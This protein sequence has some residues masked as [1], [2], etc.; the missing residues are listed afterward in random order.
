MTTLLKA[1]LSGSTD[2][3][4]MSKIYLDQLLK[5]PI[6]A[7]LDETEQLFAP[8]FDEEGMRDLREEFNY[9]EQD[10]EGLQYDI[11]EYQEI[12]FL[13][14]KKEPKLSDTSKQHPVF[15]DT[16][17]KLKSAYQELTRLEPQ[18][19]G[20]KKTYNEWL[21]LVLERDDGKDVT[22]EQVA[23]II[24]SDESGL[25]KEE[26]IKILEIGIDLLRM[27]KKRLKIQ[28]ESI[29][30]LPDP[31]EVKG[32][33]KEMD[34]EQ[35]K[36]M[37]DVPKRNEHGVKVSGLS[38][39]ERRQEIGQIQA[40]FNIKI[41]QLFEKDSQLKERTKVREE[42]GNISSRINAGLKE[43]KSREKGT[44]LSSP[45]GYEQI[46]HPRSKK[47]R[48]GRTKDKV[49]EHLK[50]P[51]KKTPISTKGFGTKSFIQTLA[52]TSKSIRGDNTKDNFINDLYTFLNHEDMNVMSEPKEYRA[53]KW[54]DEHGLGKIAS[55]GTITLAPPKHRLLNLRQLRHIIKNAPPVVKEENAPI[56]KRILNAIE[57]E[58][59]LE[60]EREKKW[61]QKLTVGGEKRGKLAISGL[62]KLLEKMKSSLR[63]YDFEGPLPKAFKEQLVL[64][65]KSNLK[66][67]DLVKLSKGKLPEDK[68]QGM[69][70]EDM[71]EPITELLNY[72]FKGKINLIDVITEN[73]SKRESVEE[74][75]EG[76]NYIQEYMDKLYAELNPFLSGEEE[77]EEE[78]SIDHAKR[79]KVF[80]TSLVTIVKRLDDENITEGSQAYSVIIRDIKEKFSHLDDIMGDIE[81]SLE[82]QD[83]KQLDNIRDKFRE[84]LDL[85][86]ERKPKL[87]H[88]I[89]GE[90]E[91][92]LKRLYEYVAEIQE[93]AKSGGTVTR[94]PNP[95]KDSEIKS[96]IKAEIEK[97]DKNLDDK[98]REERIEHIRESYP[99]EEYNQELDAEDWVK[100]YLRIE[101]KLV[102]SDEGIPSFQEVE[103]NYKNINDKLQAYVNGHL[104]SPKRQDYKGKNSSSRYKND[105]QR[106]QALIRRIAKGQQIDINDLK[107]RWKPNFTK[108]VK[109]EIELDIKEL[110]NIEIDEEY[111]ESD[112]GHRETEEL[113]EGREGESY[114]ELTEE[115]REN[116]GDM[117]S[118]EYEEQSAEEDEERRAQEIDQD[119]L[120]QQQEQEE[121]EEEGEG[122]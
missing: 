42:I 63:R 110:D 80:L 99:L 71:L 114:E 103:G 66:T 68:F 46:E 25:S 2:P 32:L 59:T 31:K 6:R 113:L 50:K 37:A 106:R 43:I 92:I 100:H 104:P 47:E 26:E 1:Y 83:R 24:G 39:S 9:L 60:E 48:E 62:V 112:V 54:A 93:N 38:H 118:E 4:F 45:V 97:L 74:S 109:R 17:K 10:I 87:P 84:Y 61:E 67:W 56:H 86:E 14:E 76:A 3:F 88:K 15:I 122:V 101:E 55:S 105:L 34:K 85:E 40:R 29:L 77:P 30:N 70:S 22:R 120:E 64:L 69:L 18:L 5:M 115:E 111:D 53:K 107:W 121:L 44:S 36:V 12:I 82:E 11:K 108:K 33:I 57:K 72:S 90:V 20:L 117:T 89:K 95:I 119:Y 21:N 75:T 78:I 8:V 81:H 96:K 13:Y 41:N 58:I 16:Q 52:D 51:E 49:I 35:N 7:V 23:S 73:W 91:S 116:L 98:E 102:V 79:A 28:H 65:G 19:N 94:H 27:D